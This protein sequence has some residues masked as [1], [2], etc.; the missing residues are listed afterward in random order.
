MKSAT[1]FNER[2]KGRFFFTQRFGPVVVNRVSENAPEECF[3]VEILSIESALTL[4]ERI[5]RAL[6]RN[7]FSVSSPLCFPVFRKLQSKK[8]IGSAFM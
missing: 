1:D 7:S 8:V 5:P 4:L 3:D 2:F 6:Q